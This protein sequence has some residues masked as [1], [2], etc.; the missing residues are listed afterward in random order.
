MGHPARIAT[1]AI[2]CLSYACGDPVV[3]IGDFPGTFR[4]I[5][6][7]AD[8]AG[9]N[10]GESAT[11]SL[12][13]TPIGLVSGPTGLIYIADHANQRVL[14]V[15]TSGAIDVVVETGD[16]SDASIEGPEGLASDGAGSLLIADPSGHR[17]WSVSLATGTVEPIAGTGERGI[18]ADTADAIAALYTEDAVRED[19]AIPRTETTR[20]DIRLMMLQGAAYVDFTDVEIHTVV[21]GEDVVIVE[22]TW[23]GMSSN[24]TRDPS[25]KEPFSTQVVTVYEIEDDLIARSIHYY[26]ADEF[27]NLNGQ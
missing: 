8:S 14:S 3:V 9:A 15:T 20:S 7:V 10:L 17:I 4:I 6:G 21:T 22:S 27:W 18:G 12:L 1:L 19:R 26:D 24:I 13:D 16:G 11:E 25:D 23:S 2:A 5:A